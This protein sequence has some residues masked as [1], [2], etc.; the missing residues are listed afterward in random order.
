MMISSRTPLFRSV[1][2]LSLI[3]TLTALGVAAFSSCTVTYTKRRPPPPP[4]EVVYVERDPAPDA[5]PELDPYGD[6]VYVGKAGWAWQ[7]AVQYDW[8]P[9]DD[10]HWAWTNYGWTW[11]SYEP[12]GWI[13]YHYGN[14]SMDPRWGWVWFPGYEWHPQRVTWIVY[15]DYI[16]WAPA[17]YQGYTVGD[18]WV[19]RYESM[20]IVCNVNYF[21]YPR[22]GEYRVSRRV[23]HD[24]RRYIVRRAPDAG[25]I[26]RYTGVDVVKIH[27]KTHPVRGN[28]K[29]LR[30]IEF[31]PEEQARVKRYKERS[32]KDE[33]AGKQN[34]QDR[35][36]PIL[37]P[38][39]DPKTI[40][41][42]PNIMTR[43]DSP[44]GRDGQHDAD[45]DLRRP[46][47]RRGTYDPRL[48]RQD[49][50]GQGKDADIKSEPGRPGDRGKKNVPKKD[51]D[52]AKNDENGAKSK[53]DAK[54]KKDTAKSKKDEAKSKKK[55]KKSDK[56]DE[57]SKKD[58]G[59][60][61]KKG[62]G[63]DKKDNDDKNDSD[64]NEND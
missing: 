23:I 57:D 38:D 15:R 6:W 47:N 59:S 16:A 18:P 36:I 56:E 13:V 35:P 33:F 55:G 4:P 17:P 11:V 22:V 42:G 1:L 21:T 8:R 26:H 12:F 14:W 40:D 49:P 27:V 53:G 24:N 7:P 54:S 34:R 39:R 10:G 41:D 62:K 45:S 52:A 63:S 20:W 61:E 48:K 37:P 5:F 64:D 9:Y 30:R 51:G 28:K 46:G 50:R 25:Y 2:R 29:G 19:P 31:P 60:S 44:R 32:R 43:P 3:V 58:E